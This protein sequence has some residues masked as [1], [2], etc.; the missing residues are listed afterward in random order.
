MNDNF[1]IIALFVLL[2]YSI[3]LIGI[4]MNIYDW[5]KKK[6]KAFYL[7]SLLFAKIL[8]L[9]GITVLMIL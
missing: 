2:S 9:I 7:K 6:K 1:G 5:I 4:V 8:L 3:G